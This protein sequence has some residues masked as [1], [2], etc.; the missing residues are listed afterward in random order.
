MYAQ[1]TSYDHEKQLASLTASLPTR[2]AHPTIDKLTLLADFRHYTKAMERIQLH[3]DCI[4]IQPDYSRH[5]QYRVETAS[6]LFIQ[7]TCPVSSPV[8]HVR[9]EFNPNK[10]NPIGT[11]WH[12]LLPMLKNKR[13]SRIDY[14]IDYDHDLSLYQ[15][16]TERPRTGNIFYG[17][18]QSI[19]TIYLG[20]RNSD[21]Q[22]R[23]YDKAKEQGTTGTHWRI[24]QQ[25][26]L[27]TTTE[28]WM[29]RPF[30]DLIGW[31]PDTFTGNY[32]DDLHLHDLHKHP[33]NWKRLSRRGRVKYRAMIKD[34]S[35]V[36][37]MP[38]KPVTTFQQGARPLEAFLEDLLI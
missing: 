22:Y 26:R 28:F 13:L 19:E 14:A 17:A 33:N 10:L 4:D 18:D 2:F 31:K 11:L 9:I 12:T 7:I 3:A 21:N 27:G 23:I 16:T 6:D 30:A 1:F 25:L 36:L 15:W 35:R 29:L 38:V 32:T 37:H 34:S 8:P 24:E 20:K 5:Y